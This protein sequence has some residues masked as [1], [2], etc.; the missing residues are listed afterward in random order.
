M[1]DL[2]HLIEQLIV[3]V[4][5]LPAG[6]RVDPHSLILVD[7]LA[8]AGTVRLIG[9]DAMVRDHHS[10]GQEK[11]KDLWMV[12]VVTVETSLVESKPL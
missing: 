7:E 11:L 3:L 8:D 9:F 6:W 10:K 4:L 5:H 2:P 12:V 1:E